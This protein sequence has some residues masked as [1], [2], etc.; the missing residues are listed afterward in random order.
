MDDPKALALFQSVLKKTVARQMQW[1]TTADPD[2]LIAPMMN[3]YQLSLKPYTSRDNWGQPE[4][5]PQLLLKD[6][7]DN[8][9]AEIT[10][11]VDGVTIAE[12]N[13]LLVFARRIALNA[14]DHIDEIL[15][16]LEKGE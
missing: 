2:V 8:V 3:K 4:G 14:D 11:S 12:L 1:E 5:S 9:L 6:L 13:A 7:L 16:E 10:T 15:K